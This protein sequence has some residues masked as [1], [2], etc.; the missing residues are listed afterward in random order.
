M[1]MTLSATYDT[2]FDNKAGSMNNVA[3]SNG[4]NGL[5]AR[6]PTF[7]DLPSFPNI[8]GA[9]AVASWNSPNCGTC[10]NLMYPDTGKSINVLAID[11]SG[12][13]FNIAQQALDNLTN[14]QGTAKGKVQVVVQ[15]VPS[16]ACGL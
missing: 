2:T 1:T 16:S 12:V 8:G 5:A 9:F 10:W 7:G 15:Q 4:P 11:V 13:G 6:F 14:G 3:C